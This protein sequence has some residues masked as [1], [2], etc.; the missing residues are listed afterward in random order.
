[1]NTRVYSAKQIA[2]LKGI[3]PSAVHLAA[4]RGLLR[5]II[6]K[7]R[8][9]VFAQTDVEQYLQRRPGRKSKERNSAGTQGGLEGTL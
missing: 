2:G 7:D 6:Q 9:I 8:R 3:T 1:M 4:R 5:K